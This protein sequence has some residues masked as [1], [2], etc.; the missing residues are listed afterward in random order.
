MN[1]MVLILRI[2]ISY[3]FI[4]N[5]WIKLTYPK[6]FIIAVRYYVAIIFLMVSGRDY[7]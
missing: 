1:A 2:F 4:V 7:C 3:I 5:G 6:D